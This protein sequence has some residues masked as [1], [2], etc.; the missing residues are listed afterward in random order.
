M[1]ELLKQ[2]AANA[3]NSKQHH[4]MATS[5]DSFFSKPVEGYPAENNL[6]LTH[7]FIFGGVNTAGTG[8]TV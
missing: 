1:K 4:L 5:G 3:L 6:A 7:S 2:A 8:K